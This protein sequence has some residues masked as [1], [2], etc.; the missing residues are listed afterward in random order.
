[1]KQLWNARAGPVRNRTPKEAQKRAH[2][3][4]LG[5]CASPSSGGVRAYLIGRLPRAH[6]KL[7]HNPKVTALSDEALEVLGKMGQPQ[8]AEQQ[9]IYRGKVEASILSLPIDAE[10]PLTRLDINKKLA[11][12]YPV[13]EVG[14]ALDR[15]VRSG[16]VASSRIYVSKRGYSTVY[17]SA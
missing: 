5:Q 13:S 6:R 2:Q 8:I 3:S 4:K 15:L 9:G 7:K 12:D 1:M 10:R 16:E 17:Q 11:S 14:H